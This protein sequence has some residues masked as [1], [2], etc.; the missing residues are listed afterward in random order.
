MLSR[1]KAYI[2]KAATIILVCNAAVQIMQSFNWN[3]QPVEAG[4]EQ[5]SILASIAS[6]FAVLL[7]PVGFGVW[8]LAAAAITGFI[9]KRK[10][11]RH[12]GG[13]L[14]YDKPD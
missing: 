13:S 1:G 9:A 11:S 6:P 7:I 4:M 5:N 10:C 2:K 3:F 8:R 12:A 14:Q